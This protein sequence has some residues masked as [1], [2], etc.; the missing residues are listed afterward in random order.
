MKLDKLDFAV[1]LIVAICLAGVA[2]AAYLSDPARQPARVAYLYPATAAQQNVWMAP[3]NDPKAQQQATFS[4]FGVYDFDF[5]PDG[6]WLAFAERSGTGAVTLRLRDLATGQTR[7]LVDCPALAANCTSPVYSPDGKTLA[8]QRAESVGAGYGLSRIWLVD[9]TSAGYE[10][11]PLI[12]DSQVVGHSALWSADSNTIAFYSADRTQ[13]GILI[14]EFVPRDGS[15]IQLRFIPS[16]HGTMGTISPNGQQVIFP[17][18]VRRN[19]Q[20]FS[21]LQ[22]ADLAT[23]EFAA[24]TAADGP[25]DDV[26][27][28]WSPDG[29]T[30]AFARRYTD[31]RWTAGHQLYLR[32]RSAAADELTPIAYDERYNTSYLRWNRSGDRLALQRFPLWNADGADDN[33]SR[34]EVWVHNLETGQSQKI[35]EDAYLPRWVAG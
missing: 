14:Y 3:I 27:A 25:W 10:T 7:D 31:E 35:I 29:E 21:H 5:S 33:M 1:I 19:D 13:P 28:R 17:D 15:D 9:M 6:R 12:A 22:I 18:L 30:V 8:Y 26:S 4:E 23:K 24:F 11:I 32:R 20:F 34:P 2:I 16:A